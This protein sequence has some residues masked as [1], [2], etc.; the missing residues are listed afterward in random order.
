MSEPKVYIVILNWKNEKVTLECL[1]SVVQV[2]DRR[3]CLSD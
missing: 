2:A 1:D 3:T